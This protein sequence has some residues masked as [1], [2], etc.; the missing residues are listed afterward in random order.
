MTVSIGAKLQNVER[1]EDTS[2]FV[3]P[4]LEARIHPNA[5]RLGALRHP[6]R[7]CLRS[8]RKENVK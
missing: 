3:Q 8:S 5:R 4:L 7:A 2:Y 6:G 1:F